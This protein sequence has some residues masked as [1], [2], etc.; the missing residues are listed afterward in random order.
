MTVKTKIGPFKYDIVGSFLRAPELKDAIAKHRAGELTDDQFAE[1]QHAEVEK[2]VATEAQHGLK[3]VTD[4][5]F[6]RSWWNLDFLWGLKGVKK[7][8]YHASYKFQG[9]KTRTDNAELIGKVAYNPDHPF[10]AAFEYL[11]SVTPAGVVPKQ[12]IPSP[13]MLF[14]DNRSDNWPKFYDNREAY[15]H[16]LASAYH[17]TILHFYELG[18]R[19]VQIDDTTWA[20]L[21]SK[22][23]ETKD[24]PEEHAKYETLAQ[25]AVEVINELLENLP[26]DLTVTTHVCRGNFKSTF[27]FSGGYEAVA[28]YLG[29]LNYDGFFLEYDNDRDGDFA[30]LATIFNGRSDKTIVLGLVTSKDGQLEDENAV[31]ARINEATQYVPLEN[32]AL[33]TQCGFASTEE[34]NVLTPEQQWA[35]I[36]LV[37]SVATKVWG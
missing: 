16:D 20:F 30:P 3:A 22:L 10:F 5:E 26:A 11:Q 7:Y 37:R 12:T 23:N 34:G 35:K 32:L 2:L 17:Q 14:R 28:K 4:D 18:A 31:V 24:Q 36:D 33:S 27:L 21:I 19:Y 29:Q 15:L 8:D 6:S 13:T 9:A 25:E 1:I